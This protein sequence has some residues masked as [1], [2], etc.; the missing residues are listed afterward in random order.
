MLILFT[1]TPV[2][3]TVHTLVLSGHPLYKEA[4]S[5]VMYKAECLYVCE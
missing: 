1:Y 3:V 5:V 2:E 4:T